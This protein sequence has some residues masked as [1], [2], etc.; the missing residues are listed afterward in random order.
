MET[1]RHPGQAAGFTLVEA[2]VALAILAMALLLGL[3]LLWQQKRVLLRLE[4]R[5]AAD[6]ALA[7]ALETL[8]AGAVPLTSGPL[9]VTVPSGAAED[10]AVAVRVTPAEPPAGLYRGQ[11]VVRYTVAG[12]SRSRTVETQFWRPA[13][14]R[15]HGSTPT[16]NR[17]TRD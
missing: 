12:E 3:G 14:L 4:A 1:P 10:L 8:R 15:S 2:L 11:V 5:Q 7:E 9:P 16:G 17:R 6:Q 13:K